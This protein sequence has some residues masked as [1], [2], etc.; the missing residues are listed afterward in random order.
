MAQLVVAVVH[1]APPGDD[2]TAYEVIGEPPSEDGAL[3]ATV[4]DPTPGW[5]VT[6]MGAPGTVPGTAAGFSPPLAM[7]QPLAP[8][9]VA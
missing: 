4:A 7:D 3:H 5:A 8:V 1:R 2:D 6:L 9:S